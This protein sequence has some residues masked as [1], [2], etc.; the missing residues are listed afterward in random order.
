MHK[1][2]SPIIKKIE[3][4][5]KKIKILTQYSKN[6]NSKNTTILPSAAYNFLH[7]IPKPF[8]FFLLK[9]IFEIIN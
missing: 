3:I 7:R 5:I 6:P 4:F 8:L 1:T 9:G 2:Y